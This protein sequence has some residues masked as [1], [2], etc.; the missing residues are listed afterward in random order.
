MFGWLADENRVRNWKRQQRL[1][2]GQDPYLV[3]QTVGTELAPWK[4]KDKFVV[5]NEREVVPPFAEPLERNGRELRELPD[6]QCLRK[7]GCECNLGFPGD[8]HGDIVA[9]APCGRE[10]H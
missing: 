5:Y 7:P 9:S 2:P 3:F 8:G 1:Q 10:T 4:S 6:D